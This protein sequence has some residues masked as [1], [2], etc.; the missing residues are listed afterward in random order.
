MQNCVEKNFQ[1]PRLTAKYMRESD[2][3]FMTAEAKTKMA[4]Q[5]AS[6][7]FEHLG[8]TDSLTLANK[9]TS[10]CQ[11]RQLGSKNEDTSRSQL[12]VV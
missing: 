5:T 1:P 2:K 4:P 10:N 7:I 6:A 12:A 9:L 8:L 3:T 11:T